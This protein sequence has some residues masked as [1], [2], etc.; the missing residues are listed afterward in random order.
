MRVTLA[1]VNA[2]LRAKGYADELCRGR[3]YLYFWGD[4]AAGWFS[5]SVAT[6]HLTSRSVAAWVALYEDMRA[7]HARKDGHPVKLRGCAHRLSER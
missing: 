5:S 7:E 3:G 1:N 6:M 2:A 4:E